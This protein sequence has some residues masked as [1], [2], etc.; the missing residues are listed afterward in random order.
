MNYSRI[1]LSLTASFLLLLT[2]SSRAATEAELLAILQ[3]S[4]DTV[5]RSSACQQLRT[6]GTPRSIPLLGGMLSVDGV[7]QAARYA[8]EGMPY[9]EAGTMLRASLSRTSGTNQAGIIDSLGWRAEPQAVPLL[10][11]LIK[12]N[13][14]LIA[15]TAATALGRI[16]GTEA[17]A[18]LLGLA[19]DAPQDVQNAAYESL[20]RC[21]EK[22]LLE[23]TTA[24][25]LEIYKQLAGRPAPEPL[26]IAAWRGWMLTSTPLSEEMTRLMVST[27]SDTSHFRHQIAIKVLREIYDPPLLM[28]CRNVWDTLPG[29]AQLALLD[30]MLLAGLNVDDAIQQATQSPH[31]EVRIAGWEALALHPDS[32]RLQPLAT[33]AAGGEPDER[34]VARRILTVVRGPNMTAR[35]AA[36][37]PPAPTPV[38]A[39]LLRALGERGD[40]AA[41]PV[42]LD[43]ARTGE[44]PVRYAALASLQT[45]AL[46]D[47][48]E[49]LL[50]ITAQA[51]STGERDAAL[52]AVFAVCRADGNKERI[53][54]AVLQTLSA[55]NN[56]ERLRLLPI[57]PELGTPG[58]LEAAR[59]ATTYPDPEIAKEALR[60][61]ARWP[62]STPATDLLSLAR[63]TDDSTVHA[64]ALRGAIA[65]A[66]LN[67]DPE[68]RL[69]WLTQALETARR[70]EE[71]K[72][73]LGAISQQPTAAALEVVVRALQEPALANEAALAALAIAETLSNT[74]SQLANDVAVEVLQHADAPEVFR[75]AW[76]LRIRPQTGGPRL[77]HWQLN[78]PH[79]Q[80]G[81]TGAQAVFNLEFGPEKDGKS[82]RWQPLPE[83]EQVNLAAQFPGQ[84][85]CIAYLR[86]QVDAPETM[87]AAILLGSDDGAKIWVNGK[88]VHSNN[89]DRGEIAD[90]DVAP[91]QLEKGLN[92]IIVKVSQGGGGWSM[93]ARIVSTDGTP[94][95]GLRE[96]TP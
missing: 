71:K 35:I 30:A 52:Q 44:R 17:T 21:A 58:A 64:L 82:T 88:V 94:V 27:L 89:V 81:V 75:R 3:S 92:E 24:A 47:T 8:L 55:G 43:M 90:Q 22:N 4:N 5:A 56:T 45:L 2:T 23:K 61:L 33:A 46:P 11:P 39:A 31:V 12:S 67:T 80:D 50:T 51:K 60:V 74:E 34:E 38:Q 63:T 77:R 87:P 36:A 29:D 1:A 59:A 32:S 93:S 42:L 83:S 79:R 40:P 85:N 65:V 20:L 53:T 84:D 37:I 9:P 28:A 86:T 72:Q 73:A 16:G 95:N 49:P 13:D 57:L 10:M 19:A 26:R 62:D 7:S 41:A 70:D 18:V 14:P 66:A 25:A 69:A 96:I 91:I 48:L 54:S 15:A 76:K 68:Q 6:L 78:G